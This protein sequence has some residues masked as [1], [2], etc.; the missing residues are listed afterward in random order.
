MPAGKPA[1]VRCV[2]LTADLRCAIF[3]QPDRPAVCNTFR[4]TEEMCGGGAHAAF[5][6]LAALEGATRGLVVS[7]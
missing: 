4:P 5:D 6:Y 1:G 3:G 2:Q 7:G